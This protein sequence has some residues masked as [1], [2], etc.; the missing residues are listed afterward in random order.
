MKLHIAVLASNRRY[1]AWTWLDAIV[2]PALA[3]AVCTLAMESWAAEL[4]KCDPS[5]TVLATNPQ[6]YTL[7]G[8]RCEGL[9]ADEV[10]ATLKVVSFTA[11]FEDFDPATPALVLA[12]TSPQPAIIHV[13]ADALTRRVYYRM[14]TVQAAGTDSYRWPTSMLT[15]LHL[16]QV[17]L[18][19]RAWTD[20]R[21][22]GTTQALHLPL[23]IGT[24]GVSD[25]P[26]QYRM[27][28]LPERRLTE[29]YLNLAP[30]RADG[31]IGPFVVAGKPLGYG[32][33]P[34]QRPVL[35]PVSPPVPGLY[36]AEIGADLAGGGVATVQFYFY[37]PP[38]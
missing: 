12:W 20:T 17:N 35:I 30:V 11:W 34:A 33:Y 38:P 1:G 18:G 10:A 16:R 31:S 19:V 25:E 7:R 4:T 6:K 32:Q 36:L 29:V 2:R 24:R 8:D 3:F 21:I 13:R 9:Y 23:R 37:H 26:G 15:T 14:D 27:L 28:L 22:G 5:L